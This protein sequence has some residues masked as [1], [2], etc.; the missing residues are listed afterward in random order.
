MLLFGI[1]TCPILQV[2]KKSTKL[3]DGKKL[4]YQSLTKKNF[5]YQ[6]GRSGQV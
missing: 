2:V 4:E 5:K 3:I 1:V 6:F